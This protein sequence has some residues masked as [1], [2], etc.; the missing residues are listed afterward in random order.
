MAL[1]WDECQQDSIVTA[2]THPLSPTAERR[3]PLFYQTPPRFSRA[4]WDDGGTRSAHSFRTLVPH[5]RSAHSFRTLV[6]CV[7]RLL[8]IPTLGTHLRR[9]CLHLGRR[10]R[11]SRRP[12]PRRLGR[13]RRHRAARRPEASPIGA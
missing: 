13:Q 5:T 12:S 10:S 2:S 7:D 11:W 4:S 6:K 9:C 1:I 8:L 3:L